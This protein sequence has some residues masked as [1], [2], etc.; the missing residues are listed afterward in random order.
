[1]THT[2]CLF[3]EPIKLMQIYIGKQLAG[4]IAERNTFARFT[5][6]TQNNRPN[7]FENFIIFDISSDQ[8]EQYFM[9]N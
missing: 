3:Y 1:M 2:H 6:M 9:V 8:I 7:K 5:A 4:D